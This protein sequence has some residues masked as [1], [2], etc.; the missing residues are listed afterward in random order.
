VRGSGRPGLPALLTGASIVIFDGLDELLDAAQRSEVTAI[1]EQ[2]CAEYPLTP[3]LVTSRIVGYDEARLDDQEFTHFQIGRFTDAQV[4]DY[5]RKWF[6]CETLPSAADES[7]SAEAFL[8]ESA[9]ISDLRASPLVLALMCILYRGE[10][11]LPRDRAEVYGQCAN[12]LF[13]RWDARR[14]IHQEMRAGHLVEPVLRHLAWW[15][16]YSRPSQTSSHRAGTR[17][18]SR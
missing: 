11:S 2:F 17:Q 5:V 7:R 6:A 1:V 18:P 3:V 9:S 12:L 16:F 8:E 10:G 4:G 13:R 14:Q 15:L